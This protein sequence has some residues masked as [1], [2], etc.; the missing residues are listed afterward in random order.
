M[1]DMEDVRSLITAALDKGW[2][3]GQGVWLKAVEGGVGSTSCSV[4]LTI[5]DL[6]S[7]ECQYIVEVHDVSDEED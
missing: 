3:D 7:W 1:I 2:D 4:Q 6:D 5:S